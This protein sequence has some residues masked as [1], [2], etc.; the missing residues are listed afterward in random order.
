MVHAS[1]IWPLCR[2]IVALISILNRDTWSISFPGPGVWLRQCSSSRMDWLNIWLQA[3][4]TPG[5]G[6]QQCL[7]LLLL[8]EQCRYPLN[9][10]HFYHIFHRSKNG[11]RKNSLRSG[12]VDICFQLGLTVKFASKSAQ[13]IHCLVNATQV[14]II[15]IAFWQLANPFSWRFS[16]YLKFFFLNN[17]HISTA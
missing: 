12:E 11:E 6:G 5:C 7:L 17:F 10:L 4:G 15:R 9:K 2:C 3:T 8:R 13:I 1:C 16:V 14:C